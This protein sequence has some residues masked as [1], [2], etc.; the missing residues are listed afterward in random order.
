[1]CNRDFDEHH[2]FAI[3]ILPKIMRLIWVARVFFGI[4]A[5]RWQM[6]TVLGSQALGGLDFSTSGNSVELQLSVH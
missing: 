2:E 3:H 6:L 4:L 5:K 1:M